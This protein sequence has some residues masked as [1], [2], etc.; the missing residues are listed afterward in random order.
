M[1]NPIE[2]IVGGGCF[3]ELMLLSDYAALRNLKQTTETI[4][5]K[6]TEYCTV[7]PQEEQTTTLSYQVI[8]NQS[9][10]PN[11]QTICLLF[12]EIREPEPRGF[13]SGPSG[14][15]SWLSQTNDFKID[16]CRFL[17]WRF[18]LLGQG[19][20]WLAHQQYNVTQ[21]DNRSWCWQPGDPVRQHYNMTRS[22]FKPAG[23][24]FKAARF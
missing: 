12:W 5:S 2:V 20:D 15:K 3:F 11:E 19:K 10:S 14:F 1:L 18:V 4:S 8:K 7:S 9:G 22:G 21:W 23:S 13:E 17:C 6:D 16:T 24:R